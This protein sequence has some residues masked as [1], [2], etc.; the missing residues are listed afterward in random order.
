MDV[1]VKVKRFDPEA[2]HPESYWQDYAVALPDNATVLDALI[3]IREEQ[4]GTLTLR[5]SCRSAICGSCAMRINGHAGLACKTPLVR[6]LDAD[7][8]VVV[9]P[10][11]VMPV[12]KDLT[13]NFDPFW[14]KIRAVEPYLQ[15]QG[16]EP[17]GEYIA[18]NEA[19]LHLSGVTACIMCG[20]CVSD[21]TVL[22]VDPTF[23]GPAALAKAY[24]FTADPR[25][26]DDQGV[27]RER[28]RQLSAATGIWDCT[29]CN[30]CVEVCPKGV[31]PM[32][33][34]M[35]LRE[36]AVNAGF[37]NNNGAR[38]T[39]AFTDSVGHSGRL[40]ELRLPIKSVGGITNIGAMLSYAPVG[41]RAFTHGK[42]PPIFHKNVEN[43]EN[44]RR[45]FR[46]LEG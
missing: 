16:P 26:G 40:D 7:N 19:M 23:L 46:Q 3:K 12:V 13:V 44:V 4:D 43:V 10:A 35:A 30:E 8:G 39:T 37:T 27:S 24:R 14:D 21:C 33:R 9:E 31:A 15:P 22:E 36:Q 5:C 25:D 28:L 32:D 38:H 2:E 11:G 34:I 6:A 18:S 41:W 45:L 20:A 1:T 17:E 29:R 42:M